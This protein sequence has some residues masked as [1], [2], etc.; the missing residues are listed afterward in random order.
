M[1]NP[2]IIAWLSSIV[3]LL[4]G[5]EGKWYD[6]E[7]DDGKRMVAQFR[8]EEEDAYTFSF[9]GDV[10]SIEKSAIR[11]M[12]PS[13][14]TGDGR[15]VTPEEERIRVAVEGLA[16]EGSD[17]VLRA[18]RLLSR[19][20]PSS[21][22]SIHHALTHRSPRVRALAV[23]LL[24]ERGTAREDLEAAAGRLSDE[25]SSVRLA[26]VMALRA[27][28]GEGLPDLVRY[29]P[30]ET[31]PNNR[32]MAVKTLQVWRD[33]RAVAPLVD[34]L[35]KETEAGV[36]TFIAGAL[37]TLTGQS[38]GQD[39]NAWTAYC[40]EETRRQE[41]KRI[42]ESRPETGPGQEMEPEVRKE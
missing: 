16:S 34:L 18:Y 2:V 14:R 36:R 23:K 19:V 4:A 39:A 38:F 41:M 27:L 1:L 17:E 31:V 11:K 3:F 24:G 32:K 12:E 33:R 35:A 10:L 22:P 42:L 21:R 5:E 8:A 37:E 13:S 20:F 26:A 25:K 9:E 30:T 7:L 28:G 29:L 6:L 15:P 40:I